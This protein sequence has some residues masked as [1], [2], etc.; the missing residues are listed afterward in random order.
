MK[1]KGT[2]LFKAGLVDQGCD[3]F[4]CSEFAGR[5]LLLDSFASSAKFQS[6]RAGVAGQRFAPAL[7]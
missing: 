1:C 5:V 6:R 2:H 3:A 7:F 4:A